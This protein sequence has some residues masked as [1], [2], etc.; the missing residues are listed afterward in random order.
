MWIHIQDAR[1]RSFADAVN[2]R[3]A[4][5]MVD[6]AAVLPQPVQVVQEGPVVDEIR[7]FKA[8]DRAGA[9]AIVQGLRRELPRLR[10]RDLSEE[11]GQ[12]VWMTAGHYELWL[13][14]G[15]REKDH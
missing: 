8:G 12:V 11:Y 14:V 9:E 13:G 15:G 5:L 3:L 7:F 2:R 4:G 10:V 6:G 1:Q